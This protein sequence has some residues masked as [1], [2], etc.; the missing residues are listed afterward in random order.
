VIQRIQTLLLI[1]AVGLNIGFVFTPLQAHAFADPTEWIS[2]GLIA[3]LLLSTL[4]TIYSIFLYKNRPNQ[5]RWVT[6]G[7][8]FQII[9]IGFAAAIMFT[10]GGIGNY[11]WDEGIS[12]GMIVL[13]LIAQYISVYYIRRDENLVRSMDRIR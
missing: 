5:I 3:G 1:I 9:A 7:M 12:L 11:L 2:S 6:R 13:A 8:I 4:V 10:L